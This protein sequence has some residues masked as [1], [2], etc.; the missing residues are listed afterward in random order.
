[1]DAPQSDAAVTLRGVAASPGVALG[2]ALRYTSGLATTTPAPSASAAPADPA[3]EQRQ[4]R[5]ALATAAAE[6]RALAQAVG[7]RAG[8]DE[9]EIFEAQAMMLEDPT[10][11][12]RVDELLA[13][14]QIGAGAALR[15]AGEE[16]AAELAALPDPLWQGRAAD[17]R[18]A[19]G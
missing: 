8:A 16:Q 9:G 6:L 1:M 7:K 15:Q 2:P 11:L 10:I 12:D 5:A 13:A 17:V 18:D 19:I 4:A 14:G 3:E